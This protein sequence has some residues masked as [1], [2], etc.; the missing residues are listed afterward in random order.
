MS[1]AS[2]EKIGLSCDNSLLFNKRYDNADKNTSLLV[3]DNY[4]DFVSQQ[5]LLYISISL[6]RVR[7]PRK[8]LML[9]SL[10]FRIDLAKK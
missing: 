7:K 9:A 2:A 3:L 5:T 8:R 6:V 4:N 1:D 10:A